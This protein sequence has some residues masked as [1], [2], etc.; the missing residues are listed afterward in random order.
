MSPVDT[1][2]RKNLTLIFQLYKFFDH[3]A[4]V[5]KLTMIQ[6]KDSLKDMVDEKKFTYVPN[7]LDKEYLFDHKI[8]PQL[9]S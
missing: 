5:G 7:L 8:N 4:S 9:K 6:N 3:I 1:S 2:T